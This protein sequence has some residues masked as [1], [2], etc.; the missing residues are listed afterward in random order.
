MICPSRMR[1]NS[2]ASGS[3]TLTIISARLQTSSREPIICA[4]DFLNSSSEMPEPRP[5]PVWTSTVWPRLVRL[6]T[7]AGIMPTRCSR[8]LISVGTPMI[9]RRL[10]T[11]RGDCVKPLRNPTP[12]RERTLGNSTARRDAPRHPPETTGAAELAPALLLPSGMK[13]NSLFLLVPFAAL[14]SCGGGGQA[15][16]NEYNDVAQ[17]IGSTTET[18]NGGGEVGSF[19]D[20]AT[21]A[22]GQ[23]PA[24]F[25]AAGSGHFAGTHLGLD[26]DYQITCSPAPCGP[27]TNNAEVKVSWSGSLD[28]PNLQASIDR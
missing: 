19:S 14:A 1:P 5:A 20:S 3:F 17:A 24:G 26:Y 25:S 18:T 6:R 12:H 9:M 7:P 22:T 16:E 4:P 23:M 27:A 21:L 15:T 28:L 13:S 11:A 8:V 10:S 2:S